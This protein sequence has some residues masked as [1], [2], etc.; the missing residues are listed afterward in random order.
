MRKRSAEGEELVLK[1][2]REFKV[3]GQRLMGVGVVQCSVV[4]CSVV[5]LDG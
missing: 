3:E 5:Q 2:K 1:F 4:W